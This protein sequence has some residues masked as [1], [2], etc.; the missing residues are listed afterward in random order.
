MLL[1]ECLVVYINL[2]TAVCQAHYSLLMFLLSFF[3]IILYK[4]FEDWFPVRKPVVL[5]YYESPEK[6]NQ[7]VLSWGQEMR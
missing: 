5:L 2:L 4:T 1:Y 6:H 7:Q 3:F